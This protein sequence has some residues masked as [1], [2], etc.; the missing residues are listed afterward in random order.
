MEMKWSVNAVK[1]NLTCYNIK[2]SIKSA[3]ENTVPKLYANPVY[4]ILSVH[5]FGL[6]RLGT[7]IRK[8]PSALNPK[9]CVYGSLFITGARA[10]I[11]VVMGDESVYMHHVCMKSSEIGGFVAN[12]E[13]GFSSPCKC[14][15]DVTRC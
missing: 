5:T 12:D 7:K 14:Q 2:D 3:Y 4:R 6:C 9:I 13:L 1:S 10:Y 11:T 15:V 8:L